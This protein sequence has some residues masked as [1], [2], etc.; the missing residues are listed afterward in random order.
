M[1]SPWLRKFLNVRWLRPESAMWRTVSTRAMEDLFEE[2][3]QP[4]LDLGCGDG[5]TSFIRAG[6]DFDVSFDMFYGVAGLDE[7][8]ENKDIY[9][10]APEEYT[11]EISERPDYPITVGLDHKPALLEKSRRLDFYEELIEHDNNTPLPFDDGEFRT[12]FSNTVHWVENV[13]LHLREI[14]RVLDSDGVGILVLKTP[15]VHNF[16]HYLRGHEDVLGTEL[17]DALDRGRSEHYP[18]LFDDDG[19]ASKLEEAG[20]TIRERRPLISTTHAGMW[21]IGMRPISPLMISM[22]NALTVEQRQRIKEEWID[23]WELLLSPVCEP[24]FEL[25]RSDPPAETAFIVEK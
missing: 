24:M 25:N 8:F 2:L 14:H 10:A 11:P 20:F 19:W 3:E 5:I 23:S 7:F 6:G 17:V 1:D 9:N 12:I 16:I 22:A 4:S 21:D 18:N 15:H 13:D